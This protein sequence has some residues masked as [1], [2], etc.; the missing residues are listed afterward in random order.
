[1][2]K[3]SG[4]KK[5]KRAERIQLTRKMLEEVDEQFEELVRRMNRRDEGEGE[6]T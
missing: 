5:E 3:K 1:M 2:S 4:T 6:V